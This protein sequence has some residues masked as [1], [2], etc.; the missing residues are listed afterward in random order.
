MKRS[1]S[2]PQ[3]A[4]PPS[5]AVL[6]STLGCVPLRTTVTRGCRRRGLRSPG[7]RAATSSKKPHSAGTVRSASPARRHSTIRAT[8]MWDKSIMCLWKC[9]PTVSTNSS[10]R[11]GSQLSKVP[12]NCSG[13]SGST[14]SSKTQTDGE[15]QYKTGAGDPQERRASRGRSLPTP[16][17]FVRQQAVHARGNTKLPWRTGCPTHSHSALTTEYTGYLWNFC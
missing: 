6:A 9:K 17:A 8:F 4:V 13:G 2:K 1:N 7:L 11:I 15:D 3:S 12:D 14:K 16:G 5:P 10:A